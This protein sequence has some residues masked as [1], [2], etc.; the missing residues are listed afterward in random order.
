MSRMRTK[1]GMWYGLFLVVVFLILFTTAFVNIA[2]KR[3]GVIKDRGDSNNLGD[4]SLATL[5]SFQDAQTALLF[6]D[7]SAEYSALQSLYEIG[8][9]GGYYQGSP[10]GSIGSFQAWT[11]ESRDDC[12]KDIGPELSRLMSQYL[13]I[14]AGRHPTLPSDYDVYSFSTGTGLNIRGVSPDKVNIPIRL[15]YTEG[16]VIP[17]GDSF[18]PDYSKA[19]APEKIYDK[20]DRDYVDSIVMHYTV[21]QDMDTT[22]R[23]LK[24]RGLAYH[25]L[26][27]HDGSVRQL[28]PEIYRA[29][30]A[31]CS[32]RGCL[33]EGMNSRSIG[34]SFISCGWDEP[35]CEVPKDRCYFVEGKSKCWEEYT[36]EQIESAA[37]LVADIAYR[38][39]GEIRLSDGSQ[40]DFIAED[41]KFKEDT[42]YMHSDISTKKSDPGPPFESR[43]PEFVELVNQ[44]IK[45]RMDASVE[46]QLTGEATLRTEADL[47][48]KAGMY[49]VDA[50]FSIYSD[51]DIDVY[52]E[53][54]ESAEKL[55]AKC[56]N[57]RDCI[58]SELGDFE[59]S[60]VDWMIRYQGEVI[61]VDGQ[62]DNEDE[63]WKTYCEE[64]EEQFIDDFIETYQLCELSLDTGCICEIDAMRQGE[65]R[66]E[67]EYIWTVGLEGDEYVLQPSDHEVGYEGERYE[68]VFETNIAQRMPLSEISYVQPL[69]G[70]AKFGY[71]VQTSET[72]EEASSLILYKHVD[73]TETYMDLVKREGGRL[74]SPYDPSISVTDP[75]RCELPTYYRIC[76]VDKSE[77]YRVYDYLEQDSKERA[78][79]VRFTYYSEGKAPPKAE[80]L[81]MTEKD[82]AE[83]ALFMLIG[84]ID[85]E[86]EGF[87]IYYSEEEFSADASIRDISR[88]ANTDSDVDSMFLNIS[89]MRS[90]DGNLDTRPFKSADAFTR[91]S[92]EPST[93]RCTYSY[94]ESAEPPQDPGMFHTVELAQGESAVFEYQENIN[95][96]LA[97]TGFE[98]GKTYHIVVTAVSDESIQSKDFDI[99][100]ARSKDDYP[101]PLIDHPFGYSFPSQSESELTFSIQDR[102]EDVDAIIARWLVKD[103]IVD[104]G[105]EFIVQRPASDMVPTVQEDPDATRTLVVTVPS[106]VQDGLR[107]GKIVKLGLRTMQEYE[108]DKQDRLYDARDTSDESWMMTISR[109]LWPG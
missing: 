52:D 79:P 38:Y 23:I 91:D 59:S 40:I 27:D 103:S 35:T 28:T 69:M 80:I 68:K 50:A 46:N 29:P 45:E 43:I 24:D 85:A 1:K 61:S 13:A 47:Y 73:A 36:D 66:Y 70:D 65:P 16:R 11:S 60:T 58:I 77:S 26:I 76:V 81:L 56:G 42:L 62:G 82:Y 107:D 53:Y 108:I 105:D 109:S 54:Q 41:G 88:E 20:Y 48:K 31:G 100:Q 21:T 97:P 7:K 63:A 2:S 44:R 98:D 17:I 9:N 6:L 99:F 74:I 86:L 106:E 57:K 39:D 3:E 37:D 96:L 67:D 30:H 78:I 90:I 33:E 101:P 15:R 89:E 104:I 72:R 18:E 34:I 87:N 14:Y 4:I 49:S 84:M 5:R 22:V 64:D 10:C 32:G 8:L 55:F 75:P 12:I 102:P 93:D 92:C 51:Y 25:Y 83:G 95:Y 94:Y 71:S 19:S